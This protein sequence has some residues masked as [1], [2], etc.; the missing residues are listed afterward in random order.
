MID[1]GLVFVVGCFVVALVWAARIARRQRFVE[2]HARALEQI[3]VALRLDNWQ[4]PHPLLCG[5]EPTRLCLFHAEQRA[6]DQYR[7]AGL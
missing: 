4:P 6:L 5:C 2:G 1:P 7:Q 3:T